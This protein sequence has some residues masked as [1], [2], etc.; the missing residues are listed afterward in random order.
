MERQ[1][2]D[3]ITTLTVRPGY[4]FNAKLMLQITVGWIL[5][6]VLIYVIA[7]GSNLH[8]K[9]VLIDLEFTQNGLQLQLNTLIRQLALFDNK[10]S[11]PLGDFA[12][13]SINAI[14]FYHYL[15]D[16]AKFTPEGVWLDNIVF[17]QLEGEV[18][19]NGNST[20]AA[21]ISAFMDV[22][23]K[24]GNFS[25]KKFAALELQ[26]IPKS[27]NIHFVLSTAAVT[28]PETKPETKAEPKLG[29]KL[30]LTPNALK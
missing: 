11:Q 23:S 13:G 16:L 20:T 2:I 10:A 6:F 1:N 17:S 28:N 19:L 29:T 30:D 14:G 26:K 24:S 7:I 27:N 5:V 18:L 4:R 15:E 8:K 21:G 25:N 12:V 9:R 3:L 22:L